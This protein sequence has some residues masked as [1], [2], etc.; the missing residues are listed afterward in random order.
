[1]SG[2]LDPIVTTPQGDCVCPHNKKDLNGTLKAEDQSQTRYLY[3]KQ[4]PR[5]Y[6]K[7]ASISEIVDSLL[8]P[9]SHRGGQ[10]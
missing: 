4:G 10:T 3:L 5:K 7:E 2:Y 9:D 6:I 1:M 8:Y